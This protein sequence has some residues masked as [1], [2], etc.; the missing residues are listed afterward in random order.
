MSKLST[1]AQPAKKS[2]PFQSLWS[3]AEQLQQQQIQRDQQL[4]QLAERV[5][6]EVLPEEVKSAGANVALLLK[7]L[8]FGRRKS[9]SEWHRGELHEWIHDNL[10]ILHPL[11]LIDQQVQ[12]ALAHYEA[13]RIGVTLDSNDP[14]P[15]REQFHDALDAQEANA[16]AN[17]EAAKEDLDATIEAII[18]VEL[19]PGPDI[20]DP[21]DPQQQA[22]H[23]AHQQAREKLRSTL[24]AS[25]S[26]ALDADDDDEW[27]DP[28]GAD[29]DSDNFDQTTNDAAS[30]NAPHLD[31]NTFKRLFRLA[32][33]ALH[34][35]KETDP[36]RRLTKHQLMAQLLAARKQGDVMTVINLYQ[37]HGDGSEALTS[38]DEK[39]ML[40][41]LEQQVTRLEAEINQYRGAS[42][43]H[44]L[45]WR[46]Y[47][48]ADQ[49]IDKAIA[50]HVRELK[51][52]ANSVNR[53]QQA[54]NSIKTLV[55]C[56][57][58]RYDTR[59]YEHS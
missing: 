43:A 33:S 18:D 34:P 54:I 48:S 4:D 29:P 46:I 38:A 14:R 52:R 26:A 35:D 28:S 1:R 16:A 3:Q 39:A 42:H 12:D 23:E 11:G 10:Q 30:A 58:L 36:D 40:A 44:E 57:A 8:K 27:S 22:A 13:F 2:S 49:D 32:A 47:R 5:K 53:L 31:N 51:I 59:Q 56:L 37:Q 50:E 7:L 41:V 19:G 55:P 20:D 15:L 6:L 45:A 17:R 24:Q 21:N 9:L 25:M